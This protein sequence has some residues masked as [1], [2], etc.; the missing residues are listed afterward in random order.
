MISKLGHCI[1]HYFDGVPYVLGYIGR[2]LLSSFAFLSTK[3]SRKI[4][5]MQLLFTFIEALPLICIIATAMGT[6]IYIMGARFLSSIGQAFLIYKFLSIV[7]TLELGPVIV[8]FIVIARS[9]T[10]IATELGGMV[11]SHQIESYISCGVDPISHLVSPRFLGVTLS[12]FFL[13]LYFSFCGLIGPAIIEFFINP[14]TSFSYLDSLLSNISPSVIFTSV[15]K[16]VLFGIIISITATYY[17]LSVERASTEIPVAG[18]SAVGKSVLG[19]IL[20]D[21]FIIALYYLV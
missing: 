20:A 21:I 14:L 8:G 10:A 9:A 17:G 15:L 2:T 12:V 5:I 1:I 11:T 3:N 6:A 19:I 16:S 4:L 13:N 7:I 18:I